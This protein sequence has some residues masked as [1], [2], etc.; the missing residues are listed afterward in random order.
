MNIRS[1]LK[2]SGLSLLEAEVL[3]ADVLQKDRTYILAHLDDALSE[4]DMFSFAAHTK[5]RKNNEPVAYILGEKDFYGREFF[6]SPDVLIPRPATEGLV[7]AV[8]DYISEK[9]E[10]V[11]EIDTDIIAWVHAFKERGEPRLIVDIGTGSGCLA[12]TLALETSYNFIATDISSAALAVAEKNALRYNVLTGN[13]FEEGDLLQ[14][15]SKLTEPFI[16]VSNPP[17]IPEAEILMPDVANF[18]P[19]NALFAG[20]DGTTVL[21]SLVKEASRNPYCTAI[22]VECRSFQAE[23]LRNIL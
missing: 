18:E 20:P 3:I 22:A 2:E 7:D 8:L 15:I 13:S 21:R 14:P 12:I 16:L 9:K 17:Y 5:R 1:A 10:G 11:S 23:K 19:Q 6:V 4:S